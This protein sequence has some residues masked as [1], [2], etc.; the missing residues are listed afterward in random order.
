MK[1]TPETKIILLVWLQKRS[2]YVF[3]TFIQKYLLFLVS[4]WYVTLLCLLNNSLQDFRCNPVRHSFS[5]KKS[6]PIYIYIYCIIW[7]RKYS[8]GRKIKG[9][10]NLA[11]VHEFTWI[12]SG[13]LSRIFPAFACL[14]SVT[15]TK[16]ISH[17]L[18]S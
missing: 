15:N 13:Y 17:N 16:D 9:F 2:K 6:Q 18:Y 7:L 1:H 8:I 3:D 10:I 12:L 4:V 11:L 14:L 5:S